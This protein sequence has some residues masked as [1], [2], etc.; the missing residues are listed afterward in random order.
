MSLRWLVLGLGLGCAV[1]CAR[2][3]LDELD[4]KDAAT[5][6]G[7]ATPEHDSGA[8]ADEA[9]SHAPKSDSGAAST[10]GEASDQADPPA[11]DAGHV[12]VGAPP[13]P[14]CADTDRDMVCNADDNCPKIANPDQEDADGDGRGDACPKVV[15]N[16]DAEPLMGGV[17][18]GGA[19]VESVRINDQVEPV[20][21]VLPGS[22]VSMRVSVKFSTCSSAFMP[23]PLYVGVE[24][25]ST[26][27]QL[28]FCNSMFES[29][30]VPLPFTINAPTEPG[31]HYVLAGIGKSYA[32][33]G[34]PTADVRIAALCVTPEP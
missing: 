19:T 31:L 20:A 33:G 9:A 27:C 8:P 13:A 22:Q 24:S 25:A 3:T 5:V 1:A 6:E 14:A 16:C 29:P 12:A 32:C 17:D 4:P 26:D 10:E 15:V 11:A 18:I 28:S 7:K 34:N 2:P 30:S 23:L 21:R